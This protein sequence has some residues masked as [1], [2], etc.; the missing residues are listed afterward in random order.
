MELATLLIRMVELMDDITSTWQIQ[1]QM[2]SVRHVIVGIGKEL[3]EVG[4][5]EILHD[6]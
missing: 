4:Q 5:G 1:R 3:I 2:L 6:L